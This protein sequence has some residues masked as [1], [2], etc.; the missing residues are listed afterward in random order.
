[1]T[2]SDKIVPAGARHL[3]ILLIISWFPF[4]IAIIGTGIG[5]YQIFFAGQKAT[6]SP[7]RTAARDFNWSL[8][9]LGI[10]CA[11]PLSFWGCSSS[12]DCRACFD[13]LRRI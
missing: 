13:R 2:F 6:H 3:S 5:L 8:S 4:L 9:Y 1:V 7:T 11:G 10:N 12:R